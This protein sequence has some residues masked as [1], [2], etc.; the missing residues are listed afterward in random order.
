MASKQDVEEIKGRIKKVVALINKSGDTEEYAD[1]LYQY[2]K[3]MIQE[4]EKE[5]GLYACQQSKASIERMVLKNSGGTVWDLDEYAQDHGNVKYHPL[6]QYYRLLMIEAQQGNFE[7]YMLYLE[8]NR[9]Y[10]QRFYLPKKKQFDKIGI[11]KA[12]QDMLDD[13]LDLLT[14]S[15]PPG[16]GKTTLSKFF[17]SFV[18]GLDTSGYNLFFSHSADICR[19]YYDG[20]MD[21]VTSSEYTWQEIFPK[22]SVTSQNAKMMT[23]NINEYKPFQSLMCASRGS[24]MAGKVRC[25]RF[26]MVDDLIGKQEEAMNK[27]TLEKIWNNDYTTD[28]RQRK[29]DGCKE[30]HIAT[31]WSIYDVIGHLEQAYGENPRAKFI[32][33]PDIDEKTGESNF[34]YKY[35]GFSKEFFNAQELIMNDITYQCL[36]RN[37]PIEREGLLYNADMLRYFFALPDRE[38]DAILSVCDTKS[39]GEDFMVLPVLYQYDDDF[40]LA[41]CICDDSSDFDLQYSKITKILLKHDVQQ[42]EIESNAG[43]D[44]LAFEVEKRV[45]ENEG[46]THI[47]TKATE[48]NKETRILVNSDWIIKHVLFLD[49]E[50]YNKKSDYGRFMSGL[51]TYS[52]TGKNP[53]DDVP[54]A[55]AN[56]CLFVTERLNRRKATIL[57]G[58]L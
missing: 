8:K 7:S 15:L 13:K 28:A 26:L 56:F 40:Y 43:G 29:V 31:R 24:E 16:T 20:V 5:M 50:C 18:I 2:A 57:K 17:I 54:D 11:I 37:Q 14:I 22:C 52:V 10:K 46:R 35:H 32:A 1:A 51:L 55:M 41:D 38:P 21:I 33:V 42:C 19:M 49:K 27:N 36:Y 12:L 3:F 39:K 25:N 47:T 23:F 34:A 30:I 48:T 44:R 53:H 45:K 6:E 58:V 4:G 9:P